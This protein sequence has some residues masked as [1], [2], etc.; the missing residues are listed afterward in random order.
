LCL[1]KDGEEVVKLLEFLGWV[2]CETLNSQFVRREAMVQFMKEREKLVTS[3]V[4]I[5]DTCQSEQK[6]YSAQLLCPGGI[7]DMIFKMPA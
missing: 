5:G 6:T 4:G 7:L 3:V 2:G 1:W